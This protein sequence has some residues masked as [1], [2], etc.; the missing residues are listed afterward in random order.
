MCLVSLIG[1]LYASNCIRLH[2][3]SADENNVEDKDTTDAVAVE[4]QSY[5]VRNLNWS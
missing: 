4:N 3:L 1:W 2:K 5:Q